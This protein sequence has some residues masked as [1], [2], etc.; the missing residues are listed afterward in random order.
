PKFFYDEIGCQLFTRLCDL[1]EYYPTRTEAGIL[2]HY[3]DEISA[4]LRPQA[5]W[6]DLGCGDCSK[7]RS[8][9]QHFSPSRVIGVDIAGDYIRACLAN[10]ADGYPDLECV[11]VVSD[12]TRRLDLK[13]LLAAEPHSPPVSLSAGCAASRFASVHALRLLRPF[14]AYCGE[15]VQLV[16]AADL[17]KTFPVMEAAY[18]ACL[19]L[20]A[21]L[22]LM[23]VPVVTRL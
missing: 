17:V 6:V 14:R 4:T 15:R 16:V 10:I 18:T 22:T 5:Q 21:S 7:T 13:E 3:A 8:W 11:G 1:E 23:V 20:T 19:G 12:F 9:L 2:R